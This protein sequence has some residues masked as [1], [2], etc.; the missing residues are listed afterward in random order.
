MTRSTRHTTRRAAIVASAAALV[1]TVSAAAQTRIEPHK[2]SYTPE[3]DVQLGRQ[4][5]AEVRQQL[6]MLN[7]DRTEAMAERMLDLAREQPG[8]LGVESVR[9]AAGNGITVSYWSSLE[10]I[11]RWGAHAE[12]Q[13]AQTEGR[14]RWYEGYRL[15][16][17]RVESER[18]HGRGG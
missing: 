4:A 6:P 3:Q 9:D 7:D 13:L 2:N 14:E 11:G 12:H 8:Y 1:L 15:R 16:I 17:C 18:R 5:A 10:A